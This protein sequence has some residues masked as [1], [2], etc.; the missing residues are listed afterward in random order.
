MA[1]KRHKALASAIEPDVNTI[2]RL[3]RQRVREWEDR[4]AMREKDFGIW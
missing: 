3:F 2:P 1:V 4:T